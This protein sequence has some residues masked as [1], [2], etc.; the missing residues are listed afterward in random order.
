MEAKGGQGG[1]MDW[2]IGTDTHTLLTHKT[3]N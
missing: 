2:E 1:R 3:D